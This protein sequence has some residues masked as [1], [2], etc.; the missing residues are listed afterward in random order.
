MV[1]MPSLVQRHQRHLYCKRAVFIL[2]HHPLSL[3]FLYA[4]SRPTFTSFTNVQTGLL[5][6]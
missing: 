4:L 3:L 5:A 1:R 2:D 6:N